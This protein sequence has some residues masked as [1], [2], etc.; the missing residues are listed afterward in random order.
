MAKE[1]QLH[2]ADAKV[3][4]RSNVIIPDL[5][6]PLAGDEQLDVAKP[7]GGYEG[8]D[9][10]KYL[11]SLSFYEDLVTIIIQGDSSNVGGRNCTDYVAC[12][13]VP[14]K[15]LVNGRWITEPFLPK[16]REITLR[17]K[18]VEVLLRSKVDIIKTKTWETT[19]GH[20][21]NE[22]DRNTVNTCNVSLVEDK[23]P[24]GREWFRRMSCSVA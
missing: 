16:Q 17:R 15:M 24:Y 4:Q 23:S 1:P 18:Y 3:E 12:S 14:A 22:I 9:E 19:D 2:S 11:E 5:G 20:S 21:M 10:R 6:L 7:V 13:G 8:K